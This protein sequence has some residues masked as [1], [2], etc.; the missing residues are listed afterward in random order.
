[1]SERRCLTCKHGKPCDE[2]DGCRTNY[3]RR[4]PA[5]ERRGRWVE[6][7]SHV[8]SDSEFHDDVGRMPYCKDGLVC[9]ELADR[10]DDGM[11]IIRKF[12]LATIH[13]IDHPHLPHAGMEARR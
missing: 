10:D 3:V 12:P 2:C 9:V 5:R 13:H 7:V 6:V 1:M 8:A 11:P 4:E